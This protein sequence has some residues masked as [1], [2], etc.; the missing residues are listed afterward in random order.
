MMSGHN[1]RKFD[2]EAYYLDK[3]PIEITHENKY[4]EIGF[5]SHGY[6]KPSSK[7]QRITI[8]SQYNQ[9]TFY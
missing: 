1:M 2:Q 7:R 4:L 6:F 9:L 3:D 5:Y 8:M